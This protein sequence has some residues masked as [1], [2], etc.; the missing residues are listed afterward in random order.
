MNCGYS[1]VTVLP[2]RIV[3][4]LYLVL[5]IHALTDSVSET[6]IDFAV[7]LALEFAEFEFEFALELREFADETS[8]D[9]ADEIA[10]GFATV[11]GCATV[12]FATVDGVAAVGFGA[13][14]VRPGLAMAEKRIERANVFESDLCIFT[15]VSSDVIC[16]RWNSQF[17]HCSG[18][19]TAHAP[20]VNRF[21]HICNFDD[22]EIWA[23]LEMGAGCRF[24]TRTMALTNV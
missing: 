16:A 14:A 11:D 1:T 18:V 13:S 12:G 3:V 7:E 10:V 5:L 19:L 4:R 15:F 2:F 9:F 8:L 24:C 22:R 20:F 23:R 21:L 17:H 6:A